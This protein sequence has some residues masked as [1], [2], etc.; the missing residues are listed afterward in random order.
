MSLIEI[1]ASVPVDTV[2]AVD[3]VLLEQGDE[4]WSVMHDVLI[5]EAKV[6]GIFETRELA[7]AA[8]KEIE[9]RVEGVGEAAITE[10]ADE[11][12]RDSY[13]LHFKPWFCGRLHCGACV[14]AGHVC[15]AGGRCSDLVGSRHGFWHG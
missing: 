2:D 10:L 1:K 7:E 11:A 9:P 15:D 14:G 8:W 12:W 6:V 4:R 3:D 13:K 5:P